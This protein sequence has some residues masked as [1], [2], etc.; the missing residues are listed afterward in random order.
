MSPEHHIAWLN[1]TLERMQPHERIKTTLTKKLKEHFK[2]MPLQHA[3]SIA[4]VILNQRKQIA[5]LE[6][7]LDNIITGEQH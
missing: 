4:T 7:Q 6:Q 5:I 1:H 2:G 3:Y